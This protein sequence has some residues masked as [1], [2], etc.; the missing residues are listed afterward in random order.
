MT[1]LILFSLVNRKL[2]K[3]SIYLLFVTRFLL[4]LGRSLL[5]TRGISL[6]NNMM[7]VFTIAFR[8]ICSYSKGKMLSLHHWKVCNFDAH[9][10]NG[11]NNGIMK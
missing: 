1:S 11:N 6:P 4:G 8:T 10:I 7:R 3:G 5:S 2:G 9:T